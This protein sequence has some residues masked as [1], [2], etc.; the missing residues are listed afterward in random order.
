[1]IAAYALA[2]GIGWIFAAFAVFVFVIIA[3][4]HPQA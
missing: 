4:N 1:M 2:K 3:I